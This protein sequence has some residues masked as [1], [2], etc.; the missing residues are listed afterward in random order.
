MRE[1]AKI[2]LRPF[3]RQLNHTTIQ[4]KVFCIGLHKTGT[5]SLKNYVREFGFKAFHSTHWNCDLSLIEK[6]EFLS[7]GGSHFDDQNEFDFKNLF[8]NYPN[9]KFI[10][11]TR[12]I[13][14]WI[15]SK[16]NHAGWN[17]DTQ[18]ASDDPQKLTHDQW[19]YKS[20]LTIKSFIDHKN[21]YERKVVDFFKSHDPDRLLIL[22]VTSQNNEPNTLKS[23][24]EFLILRSIN[25]ISFPHSNKKRKRT[26]LP[27]KTIKF[28]KEYLNECS[29]DDSI[30]GIHL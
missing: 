27:E 13:E 9:S 18:I 3:N 21:N 29:N 19:K 14:N 22:D 30:G 16:L 6:Y 25:K 2:M 8:Y 7:D 5:T 4:N 28:I 20:L 24:N 15:V 11:Q 26:V 23:L 1:G 17:K 10:L 12:N